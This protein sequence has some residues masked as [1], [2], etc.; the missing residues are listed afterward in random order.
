MYLYNARRI[1]FEQPSVRTII[2]ERPQATRRIVFQPEL[3]LPSYTLDRLYREENLL[4]NKGEFFVNVSEKHP[5][6]KELTRQAQNLGLTV[7]GDGTAKVTGGDIREVQK[8]NQITFGSSS[9]FDMNWT[10]R[11]QYFCQ[12]GNAPVYDIVKDWN[13]IEKALKQFADGKKN[14]NTANGN[15]VK[16]HARFMVVDGQVIPYEKNQVAVLM[17]AQVLR[18][19]CFEY[20]LLTVAVIRNY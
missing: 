13:K 11:D 18:D 17:P 4:N 14:L 5:Y 20:D 3:V 8:G 1:N 7:S 2:I 6:V 12:K 16:F 10:K 9:R 15:N 19:I